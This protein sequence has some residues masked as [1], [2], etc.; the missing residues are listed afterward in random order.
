LEDFKRKFKLSVILLNNNPENNV[1]F[2]RIHEFSQ[3]SREVE[4]YFT[5]KKNFTGGFVKNGECKVEVELEVCFCLINF[6]IS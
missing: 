4:I 1:N 2:K 5:K 3:N 6:L